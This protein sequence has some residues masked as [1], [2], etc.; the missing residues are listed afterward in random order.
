MARPTKR[1]QLTAA[2][3]A[4]EAVAQA[5]AQPDLTAGIVAG[6]I[7]RFGVEAMS[8][9]TVERLVQSTNVDSEMTG[10]ILLF[11]QLDVQGDARPVLDKAITG[12]MRVDISE[13]MDLILVLAVAGIALDPQWLVG[14]PTPMR[15]LLADTAQMLVVRLEPLL[16]AQGTPR[17]TSWEQTRRVLLGESLVA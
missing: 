7:D 15:Q 14:L 6:G 9:A 12:V 2:V 8:L 17:P 1:K 16:A 3:S 5:I 13:G 4:D 10:L 11:V